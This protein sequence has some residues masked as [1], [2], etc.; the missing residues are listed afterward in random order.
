MKKIERKLER[1]EREETREIIV[2]RGVEVEVKNRKSEKAVKEVLK[3]IE[4]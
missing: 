2:I 4:A 3:S 1:K